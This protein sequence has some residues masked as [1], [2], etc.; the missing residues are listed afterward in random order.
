MSDI[1]LI[2]GHRK[3]GTSLLQRMLDSS[4]YLNTTPFDLSLLYAYKIQSESYTSISEKKN[5]IEKILKKVSNSVEGKDIGNGLLF[6]IE[7][8]L[9]VL[10]DEFDFLKN[11]HA[12]IISFFSRAWLSYSGISEDRPLVIKET[13]QVIFSDEYFEK[14]PTLKV[15]QI[16]R[17]P[18]D[19]W[20]SIVSGFDSYYSKFGDSREN[21]LINLIDKISVDNIALQE[22][23]E[24]YPENILTIGFEE[25][26]QSTKTTIRT[27]E[28]KLNIPHHEI[29]LRPTIMGS[30]YA[31]NSFEVK[32]LS[33][34]SSKNCNNWSNRIPENDAKVIEWRLSEF[35]EKYNYPRYFD[36][37]VCREAYSSFYES[38]SKIFYRD[39]F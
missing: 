18:R 10:F 38:Y 20:A 23:S 14:F 5:R 24:L 11:T 16:I 13:S 6:S 35:M 37:K 32:K 31:G 3:S 7:D 27:I 9:K 39:S 26:V 4:P 36:N 17:D 8:F 2:T 34:I 1:I 28:E 19:V 25:L 22:I 15:I 33:G 12:D 29:H 30:N 21:A